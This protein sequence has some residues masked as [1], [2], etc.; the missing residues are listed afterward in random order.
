MPADVT[1]VPGNHDAYV[2]VSWERSWAHWSEF[3]RSDEPAHRHPRP[4]ETR[5]EN[6]AEKRKEDPA[7]A[8]FPVVRRRGPLALVEW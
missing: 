7:E 2:H 5:V 1:V 8:W 6:R 3:L 4:A